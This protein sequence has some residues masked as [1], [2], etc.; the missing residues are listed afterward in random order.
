MALT[1]QELIAQ[2]ASIIGQEHVITNRDDLEPYLIDW[3]KRYRGQAIAA[4]RPASTEEVSA[5]IGR[6]HV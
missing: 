1:D 4:L 2:F 6:A 5:Q 3:R